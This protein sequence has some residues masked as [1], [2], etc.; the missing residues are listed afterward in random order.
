MSL[1][2]VANAFEIEGAQGPRSDPYPVGHTSPTNS[3][4]GTQNAASTRDD[5]DDDAG[6]ARCASGHC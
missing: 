4:E 5:A 6:D 2:P 1:L 3:L